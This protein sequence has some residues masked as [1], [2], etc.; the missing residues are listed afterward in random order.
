MVTET[1]PFFERI[2]IAGNPAADPASVVVAGMARFTM[3][4]NRLIRMEWAKDG[5]F[6]DRATF[7]FPNRKAKTP[8]FSCEG[9]E[10]ALTIKTDALTLRYQKDGLPF[11][12]GNLSITLN[13]E[14]LRWTPG[15][16]NPGNLRGTRRTLDQC[17]DTASLE[18]GLLSRDG[19][20]LFDDSGA[21]LW[22]SDQTWVEPRPN[23]H[24]YDWYF[25]GYGQDYKGL[26]RDYVQFGG[27]I[28][29]VPRYVLGNW[30]SRFWA[31]H[32]DDL[33]QLVNDFEA[34]EIPLDVLVVDMDWHTPV[35]WTGYTWNRDLFPNPG[36]LPRLSSST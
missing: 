8:R 18:E 2:R 25:F 3:L 16:T 15:M 14:A 5:Q 34:H 23:E 19:W 13:G 31:Y 28:P 10:A 20:S 11:H 24:V 29:L 27:A 7:A 36:S 32:A 30:W 4:T 9:D 12:A 1:K 17:A 26:L 22:D 21:A 35:T 33:I 6:E